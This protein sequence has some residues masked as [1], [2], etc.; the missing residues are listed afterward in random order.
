MHPKEKISERKR[1]N[2]FIPYNR[3]FTQNL[4]VSATGKFLPSFL[5]FYPSA[6][7]DDCGFVIYHK[8]D[9]VPL[10]KLPGGNEYFLEEL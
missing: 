10:W 7:I 2:R 5:C 1:N 6:T 8:R 3:I 4:L 9:N